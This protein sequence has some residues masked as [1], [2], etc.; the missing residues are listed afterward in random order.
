MADPTSTVIVNVYNGS[1]QPVTASTEILVTLR[2]GNGKNVVSRFFQANR[3]RI[4]DVPVHDNLADDYA[5]LVAVRRHRD[6]GLFPVKVRAGQTHEVSLLVLHRDAALRFPRAQWRDLAAS[7]PAL[8]AFLNGNEAGYNDLL[9]QSPDC[10]AC[11]LNITAAIE[12]LPLQANL[13]TLFKEIELRREP[14]KTKRT[15]VNQ[16]RFFA[17]ADETLKTLIEQEAGPGGLFETA[18]ATLHP[19][20]DASF[21]EVRFGEANLQFT[22]HSNE[23]KTIGGVPCTKVEMDMD[24]FKDVG[25]HIF[26]E[27]IP[28]TLGRRL[29]LGDGPTDPRQIYALRWMAG[30]N[31]QVNPDS[32]PFDPLYTLEPV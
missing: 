25:A 10:L 20:A 15:G 14:D 11:L 16:D 30:R 9:E 31:R 6:A 13:L 28:N 29:K 12:C 2:D 18:L 21:K 22:F 4:T 3:V 17:F 26:L 5:A 1:R 19:G 8:F 7:R 23:R 24:Y 27:V 32:K